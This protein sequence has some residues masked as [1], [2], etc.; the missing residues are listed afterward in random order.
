MQTYVRVALKVAHN[1]GIFTYRLQ[2]NEPGRDFFGLRVKVYLKTRL[3]LGV[4][5]GH[6]PEGF[7]PSYE[8]KDV[9]R[10]IDDQAVISKQQFALMS[11]CASYYFN[12]LGSSIHLCVPRN[13][14]PWRDKSL[15]KKP[16]KPVFF[17]LSSEQ[18]QALDTILASPKSAFLLEGVTGSGKTQVYIKAALHALAE[19]RSVLFLVPEISLTPQLIQRV[20]DGLGIDACVIHSHMSPAQKRDSI[21]A[22]LNGAKVLIGARSAIFAPLINLG[23]IVVDEEHD[24][25][26]KQDDSLRYHARDLALFRGKHE[27]ATVILGSATPSL[28]SSLNVR[29]GRLTHLKLSTRYNS[30][31][32]LPLVTVIDLK[33][34]AADVD[35]RTQDLSTSAGQKMCILSR[36][37]VNAMKE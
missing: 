11:F 18:Q 2:H 6:E 16:K 5:I 31:R 3:L 26:F 29:K 15:K 23:L 36:P 14:K 24:G 17:E 1:N 12:D 25:S 30:A 13:D 4:I 22:L 28:E 21:F 27:E 37:L 7:E 33:E 32:P 10:L 35:F 19:G 9:V 20:N 34:R 8:V